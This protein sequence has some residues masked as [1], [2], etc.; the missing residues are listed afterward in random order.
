MVKAARDYF[1][2]KEDATLKVFTE[3]GRV[4]VKKA[5]KAGAAY[6]L[7]MLDAFEDDYI[8]EHLLTRE[9]LNEVKRILAADGVVA[10]NT[11]SSSGLYPYES[12]TYA[13]AF[14]RFYNLKSS[15]RVIWAQQGALTPLVTV[16]ENAK[17]LEMPFEKRGIKSGLLFTMLSTDPDWPSQTRVLTD[18]YSPS[19]ILNAR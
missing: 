17:Y 4:F 16:Q 8:P 19:N 12:A 15:N 11:F 6:D 2:F 18:Q 5:I 14:G 7:I 1:G 10:A 9:F 3:D 13:A